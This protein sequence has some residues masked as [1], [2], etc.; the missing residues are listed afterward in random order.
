MKS[1]RG[2]FS[3]KRRPSVTMWKLKSIEACSRQERKK[4]PSLRKLLIS[5]NTNRERSHVQV[6][7]DMRMTRITRSHPKAITIK[8][9]QT[10]AKSTS[11]SAQTI[12]LSWMTVSLTSSP[13]PT[14]TTSALA[15]WTVISLCRVRSTLPNRENLRR[16]AVMNRVWLSL[17]TRS[18]RDWQST[19]RTMFQTLHRRRR[20]HASLTHQEVPLTLKK[21]QKQSR[22]SHLTNLTDELKLILINLI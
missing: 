2:Q 9:I 21:T 7:R 22:H 4:L 11:K 14:R 19:S 16:T 8:S 10:L 1:A 15:W 18:Q 5:N 17:V 13:R 3:P 6:S 20:G 12:W